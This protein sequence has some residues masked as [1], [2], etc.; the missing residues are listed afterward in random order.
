M[1]FDNYKDLN[2]SVVISDDKLNII[3]VNKATL[4]LFDYNEEE[5]INKNVKILMPENKALKHDKYYENYL[6]SHKPI[7]IGTDGKKVK[8]KKRNGEQI[9]LL[10]AIME[11]YLDN[12]KIFIATFI[13]LK[14]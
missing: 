1:Q 13:C 12:K 14:S 7:I 5:L 11:S 3:F 4:N 10:L 2:D 8:G 9:D 6:N